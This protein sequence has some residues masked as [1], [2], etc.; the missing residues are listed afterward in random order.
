MFF[1]VIPEHTKA[2]SDQFLERSSFKISVLNV[3]TRF[4][5]RL[6]TQVAFEFA[7]NSLSPILAVR[8]LLTWGP[9]NS[10]YVQT[11]GM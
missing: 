6:R 1:A 9:E 11:V 4:F 8:T 2:C 10:H 5:K 7:T 3:S